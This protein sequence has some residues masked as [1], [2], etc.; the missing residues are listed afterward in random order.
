MTGPLA[1]DDPHGEAGDAEEDGDGH[2]EPNEKTEV[3][4]DDTDTV[5]R[6]VAWSTHP[7][8]TAS[9]LVVLPGAE[10]SS[11]GWRRVIA[12]S[13]LVLSAVWAAGG[14]GG[15]GAPGAGHST[16][17][18]TLLALLGLPPTLSA[19]PGGRGVVADPLPPPLPRAAP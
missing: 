16:E 4:D 5:S 18:V 9:P 6:E 13:P 15:P 17:L 8:G 7:P 14:P 19:Q 11:V 2:T 10:L 12:G 1:P 3:G